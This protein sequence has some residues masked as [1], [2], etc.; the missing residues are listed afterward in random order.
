MRIIARVYLDWQLL[1]MLMAKTVKL[2][3]ARNN[4]KDGVMSFTPTILNCGQV[5]VRKILKK[6]PCA[7]VYY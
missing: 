3:P 1:L 4:D 6:S 2:F 5:S 7:H